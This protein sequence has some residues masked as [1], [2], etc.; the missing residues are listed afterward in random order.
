MDVRLPDG[1]VE[2]IRL[3]G[4]D[5]P[6]TSVTQVAPDEWDGI[7]ATT[8]GRD[9]LA[10]WGQQASAYA[11][12]RLAGQEIYIE[13]DAEADRRGYYGR[14]LVYAYQ[15]QSAETSFNQRLLEQGY[16]RYYSSEFT[17]QA[18]YQSAAADARASNTR[19][20]G[21]TAPTTTT[22][23]SSDSD[24][25][26]S[27]LVVAAV[28]ADAEG[29][30]HENLNEEYITF[31]NTGD[32]TLAMGGWTVSDPADHTYTIPSGFSLAPGE[33]VTI[34]TGSGADSATDLYWGSDAAVWNN[35][36]DTI[37]VTTDSGQTV[38]EYEYT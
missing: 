31:R 37:I 19:V 35:G 23:E 14:L 20:W 27:D 32:E 30:D 7:P 4:V 6:E 26:A 1:N 17:K 38:L 10:N 3:L 34:Y 25:S 21:Y 33:T 8:D 36:G 16:A 15:S 12:S 9:W 13:T 11:E 22:T 2:T 28:H 5:T 18:T 29:N 24:G